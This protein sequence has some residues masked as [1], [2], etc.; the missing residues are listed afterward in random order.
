M[1]AEWQPVALSACAAPTLISRVQTNNCRVGCGAAAITRL[2]LDGSRPP[3]YL[4]TGRPTS[5]TPGSKLEESAIAALRTPVCDL[6]DIELPVILAG[7]GGAASPALTA[8]VTNAGGLGV[9]G[10]G[11]LSP[12]DLDKSIAEV[13]KATSGPFGVDTLIPSG[14]PEKLSLEALLDTIPEEYLA[15]VAEMRAEHG[16]PEVELPRLQAWFSKDLYT[17]QMEVVLDN[18]VPVYAAALGDPAPFIPD[19]HHNGTKVIGMVGNVKTARK[20]V[21]GGVDAVV[22]QGYDAGGHTGKI[23]TLSLIPSVVNAVGKKVP[24]IAAGGISTGRALLA[25]LALG[26]GAAWIG[27]RFLAATEAGIEAGQQSGLFS[28]GSDDVTR[29]RYRTGKPAHMVKTPLIQ[30]FENRGLP[31]LQMPQMRFLAD[32]VFNSAES[33][34]RYDLAPSFAGQG[35]FALTESQPAAEIVTEL[36]EEAIATLEALSQARD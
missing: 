20:V 30:G 14:N 6:F 3:Y 22:A 27:T 23:G 35:V 36:I 32:M 28:L 8:A 34:G 4:P 10:G 33:I 31:P 25:A 26:A 1:T 7:M 2:V 29:T 19:L 16:L 24:V 15:A 17:K 9:L 5:R 18:H 12:D 21:A 13:R 11:G